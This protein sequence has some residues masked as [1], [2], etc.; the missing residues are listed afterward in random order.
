MQ[1]DNTLMLMFLKNVKLP[2]IIWLRKYD[3][4]NWLIYAL[5]FSV[6][7]EL[8]KR[9]PTPIRQLFSFKSLKVNIIGQTWYFLLIFLVLYYTIQ[10]LYQLDLFCVM[11][12]HDDDGS[13]EIDSG[14]D[15]LLRET[16]NSTSREICRNR[17]KLYFTHWDDH[18]QTM[19]RLITFLLGFYVS[20]IG[21]RWWE[22]VI[23]KNTP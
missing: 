12:D 16:S 6:Q 13:D 22:Q 7:E 4:S 11:D 14:E 9:Q 18:E 3:L 15:D 10:I 21:K 5:I 20:M 1:I 8:E 19:T 2:I 23:K 17:A